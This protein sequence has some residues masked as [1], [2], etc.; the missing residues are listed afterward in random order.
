[1]AEEPNRRLSTHGCPECGQRFFLAHPRQIFCKPIHKKAWETRARIRGLQ[2]MPFGIA[3]RATRN[4]TRGDKETGKQANID[5][6][7]LIARWREEDAAAG[8]MSAVAFLKLRYLL[9]YERP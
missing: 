6:D 4:G 8:R 7:M 5:A 9:G 1:M 3:Q 2:F